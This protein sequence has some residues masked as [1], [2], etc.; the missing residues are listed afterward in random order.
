MVDEVADPVAPI[1]EAPPFAVDVA[2]RG[3][4]GDD[5][6]EAWGVGA[7]VSHGGDGSRGRNS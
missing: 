6:L 4:G 1:Q 2:E 7:F 5:A 3:L